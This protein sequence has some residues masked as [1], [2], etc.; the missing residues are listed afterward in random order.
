[1]GYIKIWSGNPEEKD[2]PLADSVHFAFSQDQMAWENLHQ[3]YG[4]LF[5][6]AIV[7]DDNTLDERS[8]I[9]PKMMQKGKEYCIFAECVNLSGE[10]TNPEEV[11]LWKTKDFLEFEECGLVERKAYPEY[12]TVCSQLIEIPEELEERIRRR[13]MPIQSIAVE[14]PKTVYISTVNDL[15][16]IKAKVIYNDGSEDWKRIIWNTEVLEGKTE[17]EYEVTGTVTEHSYGFPLTTGHGDPVLFK[18]NGFWYYIATSDNTDDVGFFV[19]KADTPEALFAPGIEEFCILDYDEEKDR[20]QTFW[21][22]EFHVIG[23][24]LYLLFALGGKA[25]APQSYI[26]KLKKDGEICKAED[27]EEPVRIRMM[28]GTYLAD[29]SEHSITLDMT[30]F[31]GKHASYYAWSWRGH[32]GTPLDSGSMIYVA[33]VDE[34]NPYQLTSEPMLLTRPVYNWENRGRTINNEGPYPLILEDTLYLMYS[35]GS[36]NGESYAV[37]YMKA[38]LKDDLL[39]LSSW[40]KAPTPIMFSEFVPEIYGPGH[41]SIYR[42]EDGKIWNAYHAKRTETDELRCA[43]ITRIHVD[44]E[45]YPVFS[46]SKEQD[47][48]EELRDVCVK[49]RFSEKK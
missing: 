15:Q 25:W 36:A 42:D 18:W 12:D 27:W 16:D 26:M 22:P 21:A 34:A 17:G 32:I 11:L 14:V 49:V 45:G 1:M 7:L 10:N 13:W 19:R 39:Q 40:K 2:R 33:T 6:S 23:G 48:Q 43:A 38:D 47:L 29:V 37:G 3:G 24:E 9:N 30:F 8:L 41:N 28:D 5:A 20:V 31:R 4:I 46:M 44:K 35:G